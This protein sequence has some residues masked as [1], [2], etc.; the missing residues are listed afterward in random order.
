M[1]FNISK[2][3]SAVALAVMLTISAA[4]SAVF[5]SNNQEKSSTEIKTKISREAKD[6]SKDKI[7]DEGELEKIIKELNLKSGEKGEIKGIDI[8]E[9]KN[10]D[11]NLGI[12]IMTDDEMEDFEGIEI[13]DKNVKDAKLAAVDIEDMTKNLVDKNIITQKEADKLKATEDKLTKLYEETEKFFDDGKLDQKEE[14]KLEELEKKAKN[15]IDENKDIEKKI[16]SNFKNVQ[17]NTSK[18]IK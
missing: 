2:K 7:V 8:S 1:K 17:K 18:G 16:A 14:Q 13:K 12:K 15:I 3:K 9:V 10:E 11:A 6:L 5:A 4:G